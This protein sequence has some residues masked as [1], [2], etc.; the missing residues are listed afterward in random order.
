MKDLH[1][2]ERA[3]LFNPDLF[4]P[5][6]EERLNR[7]ASQVEGLIKIFNMQGIPP[8][9][10]I[11]DLACGTGRHSVEL[12]SKG[13]NVVGVDFSPLFLVTAVKEAKKRQVSER[14]SFI[15]GDM[16][17]LGLLLDGELFH[18]SLS[19]FT[20][21]GYYDRE[22]DLNILKQLNNTSCSGGVLVIHMMRRSYGASLSG[23]KKVRKKGD[24]IRVEE[25]VFDEE[26]SKLRARW[27]FFSEHDENLKKV[28][29]IHFNNRL[30]SI[31]ELKELVSSSGWN[32]REAHSTFNL[33]PVR[34]ESKYVVIV[35]IKKN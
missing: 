1:W 6:L 34:S 15:Q 33:E 10:R 30:Y 28:S 8:G 4:L 25:S 16:R 22:T 26:E 17:K 31:A 14:C 5:L 13:Y 23:R 19:L 32:Y 20:S 18:A 7:A 35:A 11:L 2:T 27:S 21:L 24:M 12:A 3:F 29:R 9:S